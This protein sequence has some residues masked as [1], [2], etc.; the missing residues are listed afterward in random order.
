MKIFIGIIREC[1]GRVLLTLIMINVF[2]TCCLSL[3][4]AAQESDRVTIEWLRLEGNLK[5]IELQPP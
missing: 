5:F 2:G 4:Q 1:P 3:D